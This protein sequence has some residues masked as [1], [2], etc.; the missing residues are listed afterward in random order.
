MATED[1]AVWAEQGLDSAVLRKLDE[2]LQKLTGLEET[3]RVMREELTSLGETQSA[4]NTAINMFET[5]VSELRT[6]MYGGST[7]PSSTVRARDF[8]LT[9]AELA[10]VDRLADKE[11]STN[12]FVQ[13]LMEITVFTFAEE[14]AEVE[15][16]SSHLRQQMSA[17]TGSAAGVSGLA[18]AFFSVTSADAK[19]V[20]MRDVGRVWAFMTHIVYT[21]VITQTRAILFPSRRGEPAWLSAFGTMDKTVSL[22]KANLSTPDVTPKKKRRRGSASHR[23]A[24]NRDEKLQAHLVKTLK[25]RVRRHYTS[26]RHDL[27]LWLY[28]QFAFIVDLVTSNGGPQL[29]RQRGF[30]I[31]LPPLSFQEQQPSESGRAANLEWDI[32]CTVVPRTADDV[33]EATKK[34]EELFAALKKNF[35]GFNVEF[36]WKKRVVHGLRDVHTGHPDYMINDLKVDVRVGVN[37]HDLAGCILVEI[38]RSNAVAEVLA[39]STCALQAIHIFA[40]GL[41]GALQ[42]FLGRPLSRLE[43]IAKGSARLA[44]RK[45]NENFVSLLL[46]GAAGELDRE[47]VES[48]IIDVP[49]DSQ[50]E[51]MDPNAS[52]PGEQSGNSADTHGAKLSASLQKA[53]LEKTTMAWNAYI[54]EK[55]RPQSV[56]EGAEDSSSMAQAIEGDAVRVVA[57]IPEAAAHNEAFL[58]SILKTAEFPVWDD[59]KT[60]E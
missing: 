58:D 12:P 21:V 25:A 15:W 2:L 55:M 53:R 57:D 11:R 35:P 40:L 59:Y 23:P 19:D 30:A 42:E 36:R 27:K 32:P 37:L 28:K 13:W 20:L 8:V 14:V 10:L 51:T 60:H 26:C 52:I 49:A 39:R 18:V 46:K 43:K 4:T 44:D 3:Q 33:H 1:E 38:M 17:L 16:W 34:N 56:T 7:A 29:A 47:L 54:R 24:F 6:S 5:A 22:V 50:A 9:P 41:R 45:P 31:V 48:A